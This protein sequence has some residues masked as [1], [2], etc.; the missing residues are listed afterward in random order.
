MTHAQSASSVLIPPF[1]SGDGFSEHGLANAGVRPR[2]RFRTINAQGE[3]RSWL[4]DAYPAALPADPTAFANNIIVRV[5]DAKIPQQRRGGEH[6]PHVQAEAPTR[7]VLDLLR[8]VDKKYA[9][10]LGTPYS[11][12][13]AHTSSG[14]QDGGDQTHSAPSTHPDIESAPAGPSQGHATLR[15]GPSDAQVAKVQDLCARANTQ[16]MRALFPDMWESIVA[17]SHPLTTFTPPLF[18]MIASILAGRDDRRRQ[19]QGGQSVDDISLADAFAFVVS[20]E[21]ATLGIPAVLRDKDFW[22]DVVRAWIYARSPPIPRE[23]EGRDTRQG[24]AYD[25]DVF[26]SDGGGGR[27]YSWAILLCL[28]RETDRFFNFLVI[29]EPGW[30]EIL[31]ADP[32]LAH[33]EVL[34]RVLLEPLRCGPHTL[35][36]LAVVHERYAFAEM[37]AA[38][39]V[40]VTDDDLSL[41][42]SKRYVPPTLLAYFDR[43]CDDC[44]LHV[45]QVVRPS[46]ACPHAFCEACAVARQPHVAVSMLGRT[47]GAW[48]ADTFSDTQAT[49]KACLLC[50]KQPFE[51]ASFAAQT[52]SAWVPGSPGLFYP[53]RRAERSTQDQLLL[54]LASPGGL[55]AATSAARVSARSRLATNYIDSWKST[56]T[57]R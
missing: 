30:R 1:A 52:L 14:N 41:L 20:G 23:A 15:G 57:S 22:A 49:A 16:G 54:P 35:F 31:G 6:E 26:D 4:R 50:F 5:K 8:I 25:I 33:G 24:W 17:T 27:A 32:T 51:P 48:N 43:P 19:V 28:G 53:L 9:T 38:S 40:R 46:L 42:H 36:A 2:N 13:S 12:P 29:D 47:G 10:L 3:T 34:Q 39:G 18:R 11:E 45:R 21:G 44:R 37:L 7:I 55:F 56:G